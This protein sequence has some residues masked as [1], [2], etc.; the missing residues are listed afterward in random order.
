LFHKIKRPADLSIAKRLG[1]F[2]C[3][4]NTN[5]FPFRKRFDEKMQVFL[6]NQ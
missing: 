3:C 6:K 4:K 5:N 1:G 2:S